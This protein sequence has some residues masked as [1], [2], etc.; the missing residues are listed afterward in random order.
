MVIFNSYV[1]LPEGMTHAVVVPQQYTST[2]EGLNPTHSGE[3]RD[4]SVLTGPSC[5]L[6]E[7]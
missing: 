6:S 1:K 2:L 7:S 5:L 3:F 4:G